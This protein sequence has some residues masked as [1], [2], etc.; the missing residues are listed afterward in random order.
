ME[1][2]LT[3]GSI[4]KNISKFSLPY[5]LSYFLQTLYGLADLYIVGRYNGDDIITAV[6]VGSQVMH[7]ATVIIVGLA[8]G[9]TVMISQSIGAKKDKDTAQYIGNTISIFA[10]FALVF[11]VVLLMC[12]RGIVKIM[13]TPPESV[14][15][16]QRYLFI[17]FAG[18]PFILAYN[19]ISS[20]FR[21]LGDTKSPMIFVAIACVVNIG[22]DF[23]FVGYLGLKAGGAALGTVIAQTVSVIIATIAIIRKRLFKIHREDLRPSRLAVGNIIKVGLPVALQDG[24]IQISFLVITKIA[25]NRGLEIAAAVGVVEKIIGIVFLIPSTMLSTVSAI[26]AQNNGA[27]K[28]DRARKTMWY[29]IL[30]CTVFGTICGLICQFIPKGLV[31][32]FSKQ[33]S[34]AVK[35]YGAQY[36]RT[37]VVD[38]VFAAIHFCFSGF[39]CAYNYSIISFIH[40]MAS[41]VLIRI[42]GAYLA[43]KWYP[44]NLSPMGL[45]APIGS[46]FSDL[47][48]LGCFIWIV[49]KKIKGKSNESEV[50][51]IRG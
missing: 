47:I 39:F 13:S 34:D 26:A 28:H 48:C 15:A 29:G 20:I 41:V 25:N 38:C 9:T 3:K 16:T 17:C 33:A 8:M 51:S 50:N 10:I 21:G 49:N 40:N 37:Y 6:S 1:K 31:G 36:L 43:S 18:I 11:T 35:V 45:A 12:N 4:L 46:L 19:V 24:L 23:L 22:L 7:M 14:M 5:L 44:D 27:G 2:D 32:F 42:P 30:I